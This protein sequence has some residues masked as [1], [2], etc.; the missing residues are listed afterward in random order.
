MST[1]DYFTIISSILASVGAIATFV[2]AR[3]MVAAEKSR[4]DKTIRDDPAVA[5]AGKSDAAAE[6]RDILAHVS[7]S[8][9][10]YD[11]KTTLLSLAALVLLTAV[12]VGLLY[13]SL[14]FSVLFFMTS[15]LFLASSAYFAFVSIAGL[16]AGHFWA[17]RKGEVMRLTYIV[18]NYLHTIKEAADMRA[19]LMKSIHD[20]EAII[21]FDTIVFEEFSKR[22]REG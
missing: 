5:L 3:T 20:K 10:K 22:N 16:R 7:R 8:K 4:E 19:S 11:D 21:L 1:A 6:I 18:N 17:I 14:G 13:L 15:S 9:I 12:T 2:L